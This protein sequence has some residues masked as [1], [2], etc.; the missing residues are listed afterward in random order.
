M[1]PGLPGVRRVGLRCLIWVVLI[2]AVATPG[3]AAPRYGRPGTYTVDGSPVGVRAATI[4][5]QSGRDLA[6][7]NAAGAE[8]ASLSFLFN[9]GPGSFFPEQRMGM[10][11]ADYIVQ[12]VAAGDFNADGRDDLAVAVDD[13]NEL[14]GQGQVLVFLNRGNGFMAADPYPLNG[15]FPSCLEAMDVTGDGALDLVVCHS[16]SLGGNVVGMM[17]VLAGRLTGNTPNGSFQT[18]YANPVGRGPTA[19]AGG[20]LDGDGLADLL[21]VD[22]SDRRVLILYGS[23]TVARFEPPVELGT[24]AGPVAALVHQ[25]PGQP[26]PQALVATAPR[27]L[28]RFRQASP[29]AFAAPVEQ[30]LALL[31]AAMSL[32][33]ADDDGLEDLLVVST[34]GVDLFYGQADGSFDFGESVVASRVL[35][36]LTVADLNGDGMPDV[37]ASSAT[38]DRVT[39]VLNGTDV[40]FTPGPTSTSTSTSTPTPTGGTPTPTATGTGGPGCP[41]DCDGGGTVTINELIRGVNIALGNAAVGTCPAFDLDGNGGVMINELIAAVNSALRGCAGP[42]T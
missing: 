18:V 29:R 33:D 19:A 31:P 24:A 14:P 38:Q 2:S 27:H 1:C 41:G 3:W 36:A 23:A 7:A 35:D 13:I 21:V 16:R 20:D 10:G 11:S 26:L 28:L 4:D 17:T 12:A 37:A 34:Q 25:V 30:N 22:G 39:V 15:L 5:T 42:A 6:T 9:R 8:G 32:A 40:P